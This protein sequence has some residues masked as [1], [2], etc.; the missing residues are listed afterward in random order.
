MSHM[1][2]L[3][4]TLALAALLAGIT[5]GAAAAGGELNKIRA[6]TKKYKDVKVALADGFIPDPAGLCVSAAHEGL[7]AEW[8][9]MGVHYLNPARLALKGGGGRVDGKSLNTDFTRPSVLI[10][11]PQADGS[12]Q[13]VAVENLVWIAAWEAAD[14]SAPPS[15]MG[16]SWDKMVDDPATAGDEAHGFQPHYD[17]HVWLYRDNPAGMMAPFNPAVSCQYHKGS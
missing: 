6:A 16:K 13:L 9:A 15:F 4:R 10:Y 12:M 14:N 5:A 8:G 1:D 2:K 7:P 11:E 3:G 17:Q